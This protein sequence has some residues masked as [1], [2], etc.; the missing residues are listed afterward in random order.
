MKAT[1]LRALA[2]AFGL[3][4]SV[5]GR[6]SEVAARANG[7]L[8]VRALERDPKAKVELFRMLGIL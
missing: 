8:L 4:S 6:A 2:K 3:L 7:E 1:A 5:F